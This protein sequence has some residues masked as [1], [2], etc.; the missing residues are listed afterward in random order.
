MPYSYFP[1][2]FLEGWGITILDN[3]PSP[4]KTAG[5]N[6]R[7]WEIKDLFGNVLHGAEIVDPVEDEMIAWGFAIERKAFLEIEELFVRPNWRMCGYASQLI[8]EFSQLAACLGSQLRAWIPHSD[9]GEKNQPALNAV[10]R[11]LGL[12]RKPSPV[13]WAAIVGIRRN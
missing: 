12:S 7:T 6:L 4:G 3:R 2:R 5:I 1:G 9:A 10:L 8:T 11:H 13:R